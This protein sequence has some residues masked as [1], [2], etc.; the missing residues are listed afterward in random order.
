M[1]KGVLNF[2]HVLGE[3]LFFHFDLCLAFVGHAGEEQ[4]LYISTFAI[5]HSKGF[6]ACMTDTSL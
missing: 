5:V 2:L 6:V 3:K 1:H 4:T